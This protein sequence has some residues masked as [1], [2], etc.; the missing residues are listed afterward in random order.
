[1]IKIIKDKYVLITF[2]LFLAIFVKKYW[3][4]SSKSYAKELN[5]NETC[6]YLLKERVRKFK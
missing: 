6:K 4:F 5:E 3:D 1:M 2:C